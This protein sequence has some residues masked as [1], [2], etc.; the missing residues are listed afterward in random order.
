MRQ[1]IPVQKG[2][3]EEGVKEEGVKEEGVKEEG[4][5][6]EGVKEEGVKEPKYHFRIHSTNFSTL[7]S[8]S[9]NSGVPPFARNLNIVG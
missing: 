7:R 4:V 2:G 6:E 8:S 9:Y 5:K 1:H 3:K